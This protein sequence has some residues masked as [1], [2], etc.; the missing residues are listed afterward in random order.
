MGR[1]LTERAA[2][3]ERRPAAPA[4]LAP[5]PFP[6]AI[7]YHNADGSWHQQSV[8][9]G[10]TRSGTLGLFTG[11]TLCWPLSHAEYGRLCALPSRELRAYV[12]AR[13]FA[14]DAD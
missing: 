6:N 3:T 4:A 10:I 1:F 5:K 13:G 2:L 8:H 7:G 14:L 11:N 12:E 9:L